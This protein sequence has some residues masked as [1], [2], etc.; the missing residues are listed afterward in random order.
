MSAYASSSS[1]IS[2]GPGPSSSS[3]APVPA[4]PPGSGFGSTNSAQAKGKIIPLTEDLLKGSRGKGSI[5]RSNMAS[6]AGYYELYAYQC[7]GHGRSKR[8]SGSATRKFRPA[9]HFK[10]ALDP[11]TST[12][13]SSTPNPY[14]SNANTNN[15]AGAGGPKGKSITSL[16]FDDGGERMVSAGEDDGFVLWDMRKGRKHKSFYS[17]KYGI[18]IPRFT[19][20]SDTIVHASTKLDD[21]TV[22]YHSMHDN[23][24]L[25]YFKGHTARVR[26]IHVS[27]V[28]DTFVT[29]GDDGTVRLWDLRGNS[30]KGLVRDVGGSVIV[31]V[32]NQGLVF[33]VA[34]SD[35][36]TIMMYAT[37][38]MDRAPFAHCPLHDISL[39][40][41]SLPPPKPIFT[42]ISF[43]NNGEY[44]LVG[45]SSDVHYLLDAFD[46]A[47]LRRLIG[48]QGLERDSEGR[49]PVTPRRGTSGEEVSFTADSKWVVSGSADGDIVFWDLTP[50]A[51]QSK[52]TREERKGDEE[53]PWHTMKIPDLKAKVL[54][55]GNTSSARAVRFNPRYNMLAVAGTE[56]VS[57]DYGRIPDPISMAVNVFEHCTSQQ[58]KYGQGHKSVYQRANADIFAWYRR[59]GSQTKTRRRGYKKGTRQIE[60]MKI[61]QPD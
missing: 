27:P 28:D 7:V 41:I 60:G 20:K 54:L 12:S 24:Y 57:L 23:K 47:P 37:A 45:T 19:H 56:L 61:A 9:K 26:S 2:F 53:L 21:H 39:E 17:K 50:P 15:G 58:A 33:A 10:D 55:K 13:S 40:S 31:T 6:D 18:D 59:S 52:L 16:C 36:Q 29:A 43:S 42:S 48:H 4:P 38:T 3:F 11:E 32:D 22:R 46:L 44:L 8:G 34:C 30:C 51:G 35:T 25:A 1:K 49:Q 5:P 14:Q